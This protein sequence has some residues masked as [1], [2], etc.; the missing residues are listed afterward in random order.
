[1]SRSVKKNPYV[2]DHHVKSSKIS[3]RFANKTIR[4]D[5]DF[6]ISGSAYKKRTESWEICDWR[7]IW[8]K[9]DAI[10]SW[11]EEESDSYKGRTWRHER[12][13]TLDKWLQYWKKCV[14]RK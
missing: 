5:K 10:D 13:K 2:T 9:Q 6:D 11:Y 7:Y 8:T 12:F 4:Q 14:V 3:K 1:M